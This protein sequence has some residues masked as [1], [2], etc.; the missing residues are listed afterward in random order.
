MLAASPAAASSTCWALAR[1]LPVLKRQMPRLINPDLMAPPKTLQRNVEG[2][3]PID[4]DMG[5]GIHLES[6]FEHGN[7][8]RGPVSEE[9]LE[10]GD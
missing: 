3:I 10:V 7:A 4:I 2:G 1:T 5:D 8:F 9:A 6:D